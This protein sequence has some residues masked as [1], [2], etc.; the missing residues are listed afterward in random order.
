MQSVSLLPPFSS[1]LT[2][3]CPTHLLVVMDTKKAHLRGFL[4]EIVKVAVGVRADAKGLLQFR[5]P[6]ISIDTKL[7]YEEPEEPEEPEE[8]E[9]MEGDRMKS[10]LA[11]NLCDLRESEEGV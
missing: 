1:C 7:V 2:C 4:A 10:L 3:S 6:M 11:T 8:S 9:E 5:A